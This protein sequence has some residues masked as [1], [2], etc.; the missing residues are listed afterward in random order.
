[1]GVSLF[2]DSLGMYWFYDS[3]CPV[4]AIMEC[5]GRTLVGAFLHYGVMFLFGP[6]SFVSF[7]CSFYL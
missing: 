2:V 3:L 5:T 1:M 4:S 6:L 7:L